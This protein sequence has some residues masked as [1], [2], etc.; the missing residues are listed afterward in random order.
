MKKVIIWLAAL[1]V[2]IGAATYLFGAYMES[3]Y[4]DE[5]NMAQ[6]SNLGPAVFHPDRVQDDG[7]RDADLLRSTNLLLRSLCSDSVIKNKKMEIDVPFEDIINQAMAGDS[8]ASVYVFT[9]NDEKDNISYGSWINVYRVPSGWQPEKDGEVVLA[10]KFTD[11]F[12]IMDM[13]RANADGYGDTLRQIANEKDGY[14]IMIEEYAIKGTEL[15]PITISVLDEN[16]NVS[17]TINPHDSSE[18]GSEWRIFRE[19]NAW[20]LGGKKGFSCEI[21][22]ENMDDKNLLKLRKHAMEMVG[23]IDY[24]NPQYNTVEEDM[25]SETKVTPF[26]IEVI[27]YHVTDPNEPEGGKYGCVHGVYCSYKS[28]MLIIWG[29]ILISWTVFYLIILGIVRVCKSVGGRRR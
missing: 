13:E 12:A 5:V 6:Y 7:T 24:D 3:L 8:C 25:Y 17:E 23:D 14:S 11:S 27:G 4:Y 16:N 22:G 15:V 10:P 18:F 19:D 1:L 21:P 20:I 26:S 28:I 2:F 29:G 9:S